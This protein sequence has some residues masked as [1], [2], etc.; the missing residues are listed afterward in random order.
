MTT[1]SRPDQHALRCA[2]DMQPRLPDGRPYLPPSGYRTLLD[3]HCQGALPDVG[4][5]ARSALLIAEK[6]DAE[7]PPR[8]PFEALER[9]VELLGRDTELAQAI[10]DWIDRPIKPASGYDA[11]IDGYR[12]YIGQQVQ[13]AFA[14]T[15]PGQVALGCLEVAKALDVRCPTKADEAKRKLISLV[16]NAQIKKILEREWHQ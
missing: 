14:K 16:G 13:P 12:A 8:S 2:A 1:K 6:L 15:A 5:A 9:L 4:L 3:I 11:A 10:K 7:N